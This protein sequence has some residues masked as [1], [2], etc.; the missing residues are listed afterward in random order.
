MHPYDIQTLTM[1]NKN[2]G[3]TT[4]SNNTGFKK[5]SPSLNPAASPK[6]TYRL[7]APLLRHE[8]NKTTTISEN[9]LN[10][11]PNETLNS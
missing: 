4:S 10:E 5:M 3:K 11:I 9:R 2:Y 6:I 1:K 8:L 7:A